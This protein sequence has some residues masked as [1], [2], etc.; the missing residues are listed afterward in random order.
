[1]RL[2][3]ARTLVTVSSSEGVAPGRTPAWKRALSGEVWRQG[4]VSHRKKQRFN[5][6]YHFTTN[7]TRQDGRFFR[8]LFNNVWL[9]MCHV[10]VVRVSLTMTPPCAELALWQCK[11]VV[12][13]LLKQQL[14]ELVID[15]CRKVRVGSQV[16]R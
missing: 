11:V 1:M 5:N 7:I 4:S 6:V 9:V 12:A 2:L 13:E 15:H 3:E 8:L 16:V 10:C 14:V